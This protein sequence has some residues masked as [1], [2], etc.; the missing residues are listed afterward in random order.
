LRRFFESADAAIQTA[1][2]RMLGAD[3]VQ[4][5]LDGSVEPLHDRRRNV[6]VVVNLAPH[7][8]H[9]SADRSELLKDLLLL[10]RKEFERDL[11]HPWI[12]P[13]NPREGA[14]RSG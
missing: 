1:V 9:F 13:R 10:R 6:E 11:R 14:G 5:P 2:S 8:R 4:E 3:L 7:I 12:L